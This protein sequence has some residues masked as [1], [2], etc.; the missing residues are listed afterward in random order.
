MQSFL[1]A[2]G[3]P[4][5]VAPGEAEAQCVEL[6][7][8]GLV[9]G[10]ISDDSDVWA[11]GVKNL[12]RHLFSKSKN[13]QHYD[14]RVIHK[15]LGLTQS[16]FVGLALLSGGDYSPGLAGVG[17]VNALEL[18]SE[19]AMS[20]SS[21]QPEQET[22]STL[23]SIREWMASFDSDLSE[24]IT[25]RRKLRSV[26]TK[27][28]DPERIAMIAN[29]D[30]VAAYFRPNVDK[31]KEKFRWRAADVERVRSFLYSM[32]GWDDEKFE[33]KTLIALQRW[34]DFITR[35]TSYQRHIT[36]FT[37]KLQQCPAEQKTSLTKRVETALAKLAK[38]TGSSTSLCAVAE[39]TSHDVPKK[40]VRR[41]RKTRTTRKCGSPADVNPCDDSDFSDL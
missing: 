6:E 17:V 20:K 12:Y 24:P 19:F 2:C 29:P 21:D 31:S 28:N 35:K 39:K 1:T 37:H 25:L 18:L 13:V 41:S 5:V 33:K 40:R 15:S 11:F 4:W 9:Q 34:N 16:D 22:L 7:S 36:S 27:N 14:S 23:T 3:I 26:I 8:L 38:R 30:I 32:L 10:V